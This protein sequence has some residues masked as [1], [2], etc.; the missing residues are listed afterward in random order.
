MG[1]MGSALFQAPGLRYASEAVQVLPSSCR[2]VVSDPAALSA[3][4]DWSGGSSAHSSAVVLIHIWR[5]KPAWALKS[6]TYHAHA[7]ARRADAFT[8]LDGCCYRLVLQDI[9]SLQRFP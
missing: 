3:G 7:A 5:F 6:G 8:L 2:T 4:S 1:S 9:A